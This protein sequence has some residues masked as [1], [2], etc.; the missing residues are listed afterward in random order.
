VRDVAEGSQRTKWIIRD[1]R[2]VDENPHIRLSIASVELPDGTVFDQFV[3]RMR[4]SAMTVVLDEAGRHVLMVWRHRFIIDRWVWEL[5]GGY[6]DPAEDGPAAAAREVEEE[7]GWRVPVVSH[8]LTFQPVVG[9]ADCP[10][11]I[12]IA[13]GAVRVGDPDLNETEA[14]RWVPLADIPA[15][16]AG[17]EI[18]G[19]ATIIGAQFALAPA[20]L[21]AR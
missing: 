3:M 11:E 13:H 12:Y 19:A 10:Q 1:E 18:V 4:R 5:P 14:V 16:I 21:S 17:G 6:V 7:T 9:S 20:L 2:L 8:L 15:M